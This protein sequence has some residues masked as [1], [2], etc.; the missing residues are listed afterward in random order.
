[1]ASGDIHEGGCL[2]GAMRFHAEQDHSRTATHCFCRMCR[3]ANG[4]TF[5]TWVA[6]TAERFAF[7]SGT[8]SMFHS[9]DLAERSFC[10]TCGGA[11]TFQAVG[12]PK[13]PPQ[14][15]WITLGS[16]DRPGD[17]TPTHHI[18]TDDKPAWLQVDDELPRFPSQLPWLRTQDELARHTVPDTSYDD[19][20]TGQLG[21]GDSFEGGCLCG[22]LR[23]CATVGETPPTGHCHCGMC[24]KATGATLF[25]WIE[26]A[27]ENFAFTRG[28]PRTFSSSHLAQ[29]NFCETCGC[30]IAFRF[31]SDTEDGNES[32]W[33]P[34]GSAD[35]P[36]LFAPTHQ[37]FIRD[38]LPWLRLAGE[39]REWPGQLSW[40]PSDDSLSSP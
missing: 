33:V 2:C 7:T 8:P 39:L 16:M 30:Q 37:I 21:N 14:V 15:I 20:Q 3:K 26:I 40:A 23:Y 1:M 22:A 29:R 25:S 4:G 28:E 12:D 34:L 27:A 18:F 9:S 17:I 38:R 31:S 36:G 19:P 24:R 10:G 6:H 13:G 32:Y 11:M 5:V 35:Q